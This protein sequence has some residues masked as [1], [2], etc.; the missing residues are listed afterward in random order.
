MK[1]A[2]LLAVVCI[3]YLSGQS[4]NVGVGTNTPLVKMDIK[5][6]LAGVK[7]LDNHQ[8]TSDEIIKAQQQQIEDLKNRLEALEKKLQ[9]K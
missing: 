1:R 5:G 9:T 4:Q 8:Q 3:A 7:A 6:S 2:L